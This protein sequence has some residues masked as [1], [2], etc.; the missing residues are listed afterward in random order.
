MPLLGYADD[1]VYSKKVTSVYEQEDTVIAINAIVTC[2]ESLLELSLNI[3]KTK[4]MLF[5]L[6]DTPVDLQIKPNLA[7]VLTEQVH[8]YKYL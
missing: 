7:G 3:S 5:T 8:T 1:L 2:Y 6:A 4:F